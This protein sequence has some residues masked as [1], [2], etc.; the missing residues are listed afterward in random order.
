MPGRRWSRA[1]HTPHTLRNQVSCTCRLRTLRKARRRGRCSRRCTGILGDCRCLPGCCCSRDTARSCPRSRTVRPRTLG[2]CLRSQRSPRCR[3][4]RLRRCCRRARWS[5]AC[6]NWQWPLRP[7]RRSRRGTARTSRCCF[8][9]APAHRCRSCFLDALTS[10]SPPA[11]SC[12]DSGCWR[13]PAR[14]RQQGTSGRQ[15]CLWSARRSPPGTA[16]SCHRRFRRRPAPPRS[17]WDPPS[18]GRSSWSPAGRPRRR[19]RSSKP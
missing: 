13:P 14:S 11:S 12:T 2:R 9:R 19:R 10:S 16:G 7:C 3:H 1:R 8:S 4:R 17:L 18:S 15:T 5:N 6:R